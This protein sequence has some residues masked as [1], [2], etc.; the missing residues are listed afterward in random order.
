MGINGTLRLDVQDLLLYWIKGDN[1]RF[2]YINL[3][4]NSFLVIE[5]PT[6][7]LLSRV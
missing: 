7:I 5:Y 4:L 2:A 3:R 1:D 6:L